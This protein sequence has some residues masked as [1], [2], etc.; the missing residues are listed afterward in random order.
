MRKNE[1]NIGRQTK[2]LTTNMTVEA[3]E[4]ED[5]EEAENKKKKKRKKDTKT[6]FGDSTV[7]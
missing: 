6:F 1:S 7:P 4:A 3:E 2:S 5:Q